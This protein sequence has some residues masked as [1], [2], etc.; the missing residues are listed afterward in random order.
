MSEPKQERPSAAELKRK[1]QMAG[2]LYQPMRP[3]N[4]KDTD[5]PPPIVRA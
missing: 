4:S 2:G 1:A 5:P 3:C